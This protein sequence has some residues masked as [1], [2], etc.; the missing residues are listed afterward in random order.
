M[1]LIMHQN[2]ITTRNL[3]VKMNVYLNDNYTTTT[4]T[5]TTTTSTTTTINF[6][7]QGQFKYL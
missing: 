1:L 7:K 6:E 4:T 5:R 3:L 2:I